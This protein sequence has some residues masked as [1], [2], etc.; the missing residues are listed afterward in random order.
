MPTSYVPRVIV[1]FKNN[2]VDTSVNDAADKFLA[3]LKTERAW[4]Q[5]VD[6]RQFQGITIEKL[7][8]AVTQPRLLN[9]IVNA[10]RRDPT[11]RPPNFLTYYSILCPPDVNPAALV[12]ILSSP[13]WSSMV[14]HAYIDATPAEDPAVDRG[15]NPGWERPE[16]DFL[17][18]G[19]KG[20]NADFA[21]HLPGGDGGKENGVNLQFFDIESNW[22]LTHPDLSPSEPQEPDIG[23]IRNTN[24][25]IN[26][27]TSVL[28]IVIA[29]DIDPN[30][31][32]QGSS[33]GI[34]P[35]VAVTKIFSYWSSLSQAN[36][37][38][39]IM[40]VISQQGLT[41]G[42]VLLLE[43][44]ITV[45]N[46]RNQPGELQRDIF[47][48]IRCA[49]ALGIVV[50]EAAGNG[51]KDLDTWGDI[52]WGTDES[53]DPLY[54]NPN[55]NSS[56]FKDSGAILVSAANS[57]VPHT[58][59]HDQYNFGS[60][61]DCYAWGDN[62]YTTLSTDPYGT[63]GGT[64][65]AA[66]IIAGAALSLQGIAAARP[67]SCRLSPYQIRQLLSDPIT[68]TLI[69]SPTAPPNLPLPLDWNQEKIGVMP[70]LKA[71]VRISVGITPCNDFPDPFLDV[72]SLQALAR[73]YS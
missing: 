9:L 14:Q 16:T 67:N 66:A 53:G 24:R 47:E 69:G 21:W 46:V 60:R 56:H 12:Q 40:A 10:R 26:H 22:D 11:Y 43:F 20:I 19:P 4:I 8:T 45:N 68:G 62:I 1:K 64:S 55:R 17:R 15:R 39:T 73:Y 50:V 27:G 72:K 63:V 30:S 54:F 3:Q 18:E 7:F 41:F 13:S 28:G 6:Q 32:H 23:N 57:E 70:D 34:T 25:D 38:N 52:Y 51:A 33:L 58:A 37:A 36:Q 29:S 35:K 5:L 71:I 31:P 65:G 59:D 49:T 48:A 42:D 61:I 44:Q 2:L